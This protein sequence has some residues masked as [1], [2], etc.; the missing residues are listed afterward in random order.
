MGAPGRT[1]CDRGKVQLSDG[2]GGDGG[3]Y[4]GLLPV[5]V[6]VIYEVASTKETKYYYQAPQKLPRTC[7]GRG[8][9]ENLSSSDMWDWHLSSEICFRFSESPF[10][11]ASD[12]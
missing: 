9:K 8:C 6:G 2:V 4:G 5:G 7:L 1:D 11:T 12:F 10:L 3:D